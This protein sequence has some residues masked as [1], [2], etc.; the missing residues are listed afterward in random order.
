MKP[1]KK[2]TEKVSTNTKP[3]SIEDWQKTTSKTEKIKLPSGIV[4]E[5]RKLDLLDLTIAGH[6]P[7]SLLTS[8]M[9]VSDSFREG[10]FDVSEEELSNMLIM[11]QKAAVKAV[12]NPPLSFDGTKNTMD[13]RQVDSADLFT[14]FGESIKGGDVGG[15][16]VTFLR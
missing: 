15:K 10:K 13:V 11:V 16:L 8:L 14:I 4:V 5:I 9:K 12:I 3:S 7:L 6:I 2:V 1:T